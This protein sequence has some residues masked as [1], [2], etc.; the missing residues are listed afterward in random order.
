MSEQFAEFDGDDHFV[1]PICNVGHDQGPVDDVDSF[2]CLK[3]GQTFRI[4]PDI[5]QGME[6]ARA[7]PDA[8]LDSDFL[9]TDLGDT[10]VIVDNTPVG[11]S[12]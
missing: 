6:E 3:C 12:G 9:E 11:P 4:N 8:F 1:C 10:P 2:R 5:I 7:D